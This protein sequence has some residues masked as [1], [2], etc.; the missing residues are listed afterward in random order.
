[1]YRLCLSIVWR[2]ADERT[3]GAGAHCLICC[4]TGKVGDANLK[5]G[6]LVCDCGGDYW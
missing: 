4:L 6:R 1:M 2:E 5:L 3:A